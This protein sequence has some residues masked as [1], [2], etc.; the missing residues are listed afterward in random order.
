MTD[1]ARWHRFE[2]RHPATF[3]GM[4]HLWCRKPEA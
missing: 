4:A 2:Q 3:A 1:L